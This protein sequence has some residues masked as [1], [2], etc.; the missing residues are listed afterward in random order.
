[1]R[2]D[3]ET[4]VFCIPN[5]CRSATYFVEYNGVYFA[6]SD[7]NVTFTSVGLIIILWN[8]NISNLT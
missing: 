4:H 6:Q 5:G 3:S 7:R 1:M 2:S 8:L